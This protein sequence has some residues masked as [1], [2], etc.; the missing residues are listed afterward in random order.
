MDIKLGRLSG[1]L[2]S[3]LVVIFAVMAA[4]NELGIAQ[5]LINTLFMGLVA[6]LALGFGLAIGLGAKDLVSEILN[7]WYKDLKKEIRK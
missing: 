2:A 5:S 4:I 3:Y 1:R 7:N 6:M